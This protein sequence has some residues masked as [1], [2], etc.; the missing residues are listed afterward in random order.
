METG[1]WPTIEFFYG[2]GER[3]ENA[4]DFIKKIRRHFVTVNWNDDTKLHF[5][6]T[7]LKYNSPAE[8]W[9]ENLPAGLKNT[10][11]KLHA[12]FTTRWPPKNRTGPTTAD[13]RLRLE[14]F[15][16]TK[17]I[18]IPASVPTPAGLFR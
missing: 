14:D 11:D 9:F 15:R 2:D 8:I 7:C 5:F 6:E 1:P 10:W 3:G 17:K 16:L 12:A 4:Q 18:F 13:K